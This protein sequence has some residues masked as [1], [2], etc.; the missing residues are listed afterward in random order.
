M[1]N[2][3]SKSFYAVVVQPEVGCSR[4]CHDVVVEMETNREVLLDAW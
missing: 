4:F 2:V 1:T 3:L